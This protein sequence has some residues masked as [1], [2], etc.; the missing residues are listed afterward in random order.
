MAGV[1]GDIIQLSLVGS[2]LDEQFQN[3]HFYRLDDEGTI[4][5]LEGL[6]TEFE[7]T[8]LP[9]YADVMSDGASYV[10]LR[11]I[12]I[13][14][15]DEHIESPLTPATGAISAGGDDLASFVSA[16]IKL[17]R[18]N[19]RVRHGRKSIAGMVEVSAQEQEWDSGFVASLQLLADGLAQTLIAGLVDNFKPVIVGRVK[20]AVLG[21]VPLQYT[22]RLP[23]SQAEMDDEWAYVTSAVASPVITTMNS[24]KRGRGV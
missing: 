13:F 12:N 24:R 4:N 15:L 14:S 22:Y 1:E 3:V 10:E 11:A 6:C 23:T 9:L 7:S 8:V 20:T 2:F 5:Y 17:V 16:S 18:G 21:T 19:A